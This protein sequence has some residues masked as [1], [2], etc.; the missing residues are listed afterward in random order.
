MDAKLVVVGGNATKGEVKLKLPMTIG[1]DKRAGLCIAH[2]MVSRVHCTLF[3]SDGMLMLRDNNSANGTFINDQRVRNQATIM[4][5]DKLTVGPLTFVAIYKNAAGKKP[6]LTTS[7]T[8]DNSPGADIDLTGE[9]N[10]PSAFDKWLR[11]SDA[12]L[13]D[14][15]SDDNNFPADATALAG[16]EDWPLGRDPDELDENQPVN[17]QDFFKGLVEMSDEDSMM[18]EKPHDE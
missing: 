14:I 1:R 5:G 10:G 6:S 3:E 4:P 15:F 17:L 16:G 11:D 8:D 7:A 13:E 2:P 12:G 9:G 18:N